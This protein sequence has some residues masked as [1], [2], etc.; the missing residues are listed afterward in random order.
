MRAE[1]WDAVGFIG[2]WAGVECELGTE[3]LDAAEEVAAS[4][5]DE[6][7]AR[8]EEAWSAVGRTGVVDL[9]GVAIAKITAANMTHFIQPE[10]MRTICNIHDKTDLLIGN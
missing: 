8:P 5:P 1:C 4:M 6:R 2:C 10:S 3:G 9:E 7:L